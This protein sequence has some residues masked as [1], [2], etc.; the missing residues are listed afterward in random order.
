MK[1]V[2]RRRQ[3]PALFDPRDGVAAGGAM[4]GHGSGAL[5]RDRREREEEAMR[6]RK[7]SSRPAT[8]VASVV[9]RAWDRP[10][11]RPPGGGWRRQQGDRE[12][13]TRVGI[14]LERERGVV[15]VM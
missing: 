3:L 13:E 5:S 2:G 7:C 14:D 6:R 10:W 8:E 9:G 1:E 15:R 12:E 4:D 11:G